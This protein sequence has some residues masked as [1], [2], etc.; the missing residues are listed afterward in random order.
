M[1]TW[2]GARSGAI[3]TLREEIVRSRLTKPRLAGRGLH[4]VALCVYGSQRRG[5]A[6]PGPG[7]GGEQPQNE[8]AGGFAG[9]ATLI[10]LAPL[11][12]SGAAACSL[13]S[14]FLSRVGWWSAR[15]GAFG[16]AAGGR[17]SCGRCRCWTWP[18]TAGSRS[19]WRSAWCCSAGSAWI[20]SVR[21]GGRW[22]WWVAWGR[23][24]GHRLGDFA[25][26][27]A[28]GNHGARRARC[29]GTGAR[30]RTTTAPPRLDSGGRRPSFTAI[31]PTASGPARAVAFLPVYYG[32]DGR[33]PRGS[34]L[35]WTP[36]S[37]LRRGRIAD[38][39]RAAIGPTYLDRNHARRPD[40]DLDM[41]STPR[42]PAA[43]DRPESPA[44]IAYAP[45]RGGRRRRGSSPLGAELPPNLLMR[46]GLSRRAQL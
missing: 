31:A 26:L 1:P 15:L 25:G 23:G 42:S 21:S 41:A 36:P 20:G 37:L 11:G 4:G 24:L 34:I 12:W 9:L 39:T 22:R 33:P 45:A 30:S 43:E 2:R 13:G 40:W 32:V 7:F 17:I 19:G 3:A 10:W 6:E 44:V 18:T 35:A 29:F 16:V 5:H 14:W 28:V 38:K 27:I 8:S 46:Y